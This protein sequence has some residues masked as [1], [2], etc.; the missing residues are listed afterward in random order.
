MHVQFY[1]DL[2][3]GPRSREEVRL[4]KLG[5]YVY[6]DGR[7]VAVGFDMT[8]FLER[9]SLLVTITNVE[10]EEAASLSVIE[11]MEPHFNLTVHLRD[12]ARLD[13]YTVEAIVYYVSKEGK[14]EISHRVVRSFDSS[15]P[16]EQ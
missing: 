2:D 8:P 4:N 15:E 12:D 10:G 16:G 13:P 1:D 11:A 14:R 7:R 6:E 3:G 5:L 9:P